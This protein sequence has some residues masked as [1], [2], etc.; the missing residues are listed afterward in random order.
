MSFKAI[1]EANLKTAALSLNNV[2]TKTAQDAG[3]PDKLHSQV[4]V[5]SSG[6]GVGFDYPSE[7]SNEVFDTEYGSVG[8]S[9]KAAMRAMDQVNKKEVKKAVYK[10]L[11]EDLS[12]KGLF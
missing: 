3:W 11:S 10:S 7:I 6:S 2:W 4:S 1:L 12:N 9:P 8:N 5:T